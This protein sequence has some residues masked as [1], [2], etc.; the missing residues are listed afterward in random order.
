MLK[1]RKNINTVSGDF[2]PNLQHTNK[3]LRIKLRKCE[4]VFRNLAD[5][6]NAERCNSLLFSISPGLVALLRSD[7][8]FSG[9][10]SFVRRTLARSTFHGFSIGFKRCQKCA[11]SLSY[12]QF[13]FFSP[14]RRTCKS[15]RSRQELSNEYLLFSIYLQKSASIQPRTG[16]TTFAKN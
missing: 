14:Q 5:L 10:V 2:S 13:R 3:H 7:G 8:F 9:A 4:I 6:L 15:C 1:F 12:F 16:L 11:F